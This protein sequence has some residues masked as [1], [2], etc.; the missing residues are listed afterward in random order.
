MPSSGSRWKSFGFYAALVLGSLIISVLIV[1]TYFAYRAAPRAPL[2]FY[3]RLYPYVMFRPNES[4]IYET[5]E[6]YEMSHHKSRVFVY[7]NEDGFRIPSPGYKLPKQKTAGQFRVAFLGSSSV[8]IASTFDVT[9]PGSFKKLLQ[10]RYP[11]RDVEVINA[12]IQS[13]VSRQS[14]VQ[15]VTTVVDYQPDVVILYDGLNDL[16]LPM[17]YESRANFPYNFQTME[18]AWDL[19]RQEHQEPLWRVILGRSFLYRGLRARLNPRGQKLTPEPGSPATSNVVPAERILSD[20]AFVT[21]HVTAYLANWRKLIELSRTYDYEPVCIL[22]PVGQLDPD[23]S[24]EGLMQMFH[25][26]HQTALQWIRAFNVLYDEAGRQIQTMA[27]QYPQAVILNMSH[28]L[29]T[30]SFWDLA[31]VYD[32]VNATVAQEI[33]KGT[34]AA[35]EKRLKKG[36]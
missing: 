20:S 8:Q 30:T 10:R 21:E 22:N 3:N 25:L 32:E 36:D 12:G 31:H 14:L 17:T 26:D 23:H 15:L 16:G 19:Y 5:A 1:E 6:T 24:A 28:L 9:L 13:C 7:S 33:Y 29:P 34:K 18:E 27:P 35:I 4:Y 2:P 11:G